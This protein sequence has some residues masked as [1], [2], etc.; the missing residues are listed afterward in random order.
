MKILIFK[1]IIVSWLENKKYKQEAYN[2]LR[3]NGTEFVSWILTRKLVI[4]IHSSLFK[5]GEPGDDN[6]EFT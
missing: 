3:T 5:F 6:S 2:I 4:Q 1:F